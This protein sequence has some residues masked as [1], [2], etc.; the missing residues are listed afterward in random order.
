MKM[1]KTDCNLALMRQHLFL[2]V[3]D[4]ASEVGISKRYW[5]LIEAGERPVP[6]KV[7]AGMAEWIE[8]RRKLDA[9]LRTKANRAEFLKDPHALAALFAIPDAVSTAIIN[10]ARA[11]ILYSSFSE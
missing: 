11:Q 2:T 4:A 6:E 1:T 8:F 10:S 3:A 7:K 5:Q 9:H